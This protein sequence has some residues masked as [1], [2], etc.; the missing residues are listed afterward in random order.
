MRI[1]AVR[2]DHDLRQED[3][4]R[5]LNVNQKTYS[6]YESEKILMTT[7]K[8]IK[9]ALFYNLSTDY[10]LGLTNIKERAEKR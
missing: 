1:R 5:I 8:L 4:A 7:D 6:K 2:E 9:L 10:L 3:I